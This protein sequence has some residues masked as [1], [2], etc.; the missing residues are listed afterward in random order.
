MLSSGL[1]QKKYLFF[2]IISMNINVRKKVQTKVVALIGIQFLSKFGIL[3]SKFPTRY[4][5]KFS[6]Y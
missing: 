3:F 6:L 1:K 2:D 5:I 4:C